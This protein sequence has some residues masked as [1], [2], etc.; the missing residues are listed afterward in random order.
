M[1]EHKPAM[2]EEFLNII[3]GG[4]LPAGW[5]ATT[6]SYIE[7]YKKNAAAGGLEDSADGMIR[8]IR[9][10]SPA[11]RTPEHEADFEQMYQ[12]IRAHY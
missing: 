10:T 1:L 12:Y 5:E 4:A 11:A 6:D 9:G 3:S 8:Y 2:S 7:N